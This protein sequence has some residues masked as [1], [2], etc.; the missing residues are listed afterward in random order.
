MNYPL[1]KGGGYLTAARLSEVTEEI[2][3]DRER[4]YP[5]MMTVTDLDGRN[6]RMGFL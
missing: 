4:L 1:P 3:Y 6:H 2:E 5:Y